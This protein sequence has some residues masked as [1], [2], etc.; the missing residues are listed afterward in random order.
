MPDTLVDL[1]AG[2]LRRH[3]GLRSSHACRRVLHFMLPEAAGEAR[4][5]DTEP[6]YV[7]RQHIPMLFR[8][9]YLK[10][11]DKRRLRVG[12]A[13]G[14]AGRSTPTASST[15]ASATVSRPAEFCEKRGSSCME[16]RRRHC[17]AN[18]APR[19]GLGAMCGR[20]RPA[21]R[22]L[23][24]V[25]GVNLMVVDEFSGGAALIV[26]VSR[27]LGLPIG[28]CHQAA[29]GQE[30]LDM[31][32][33]HFGRHYPD[34]CRHARHERR[35]EFPAPSR[36]RSERLRDIPVLVISTDGSER[37]M[38]RMMALS[39]KSLPQKVPSRRKPARAGSSDL[40]GVATMH[41]PEDLS[42]LACAAR[43]DA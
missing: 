27:T 24:I 41:R 5:A 15:S 29:D 3:L 38:R 34:E 4:K 16:R 22:E 20:G 10:G 40:L 6:L 1:C 8:E 23:L 37:R 36:C 42:C 28:E 21:G 25:Y 30:A 2:L 31:L 17:A 13:G 43:A 19:H 14:A 32:R 39:A 26:R 11:A 7:R 9:G 12:V 35:K 18:G 33:E